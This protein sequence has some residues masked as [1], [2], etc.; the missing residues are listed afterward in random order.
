MSYNARSRASSSAKIAYHFFG[1]TLVGICPDLANALAF[2]T[3]GEEAVIK[4]SQQQ[5][6][7]I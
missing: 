6:M 5:M 3:D 7:F 2:G 1:S 4:A